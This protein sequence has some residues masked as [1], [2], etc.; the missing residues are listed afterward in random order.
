RLRHAVELQL[1]GVDV[2]LHRRPIGAAPRLRPLRYG[3]ALGVQDLVRLH[4]LRFGEMAALH[5]LFADGKRHR[6]GKEGAQPLVKL[7]ALGAEARVLAA[8]PQRLSKGPGAPWPP[9]MHMVMTTC[10]APR[11]LPSMRA[12]PVMRAPDM[13]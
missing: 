3:Q 7:F 2:M 12:W 4:E 6:G 8:L 5:H 11:R 9:P 1:L 10:L 13:P